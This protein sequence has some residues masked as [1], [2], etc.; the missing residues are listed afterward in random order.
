MLEHKSKRVTGLRIWGLVRRLGNL[1]VVYFNRPPWVTAKVFLS[2]FFP[3]RLSSCWIRKAVRA[4]S[5]LTRNGSM[6]PCLVFANV[7]KASL[8]LNRYVIIIQR[9]KDGSLAGVAEHLLLTK[10]TRGLA[11]QNLPTFFGN[12]SLRAICPSNYSQR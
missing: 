4:L 9:W 10:Y 12:L 1:G 8:D 2:L 3:S 5:K 11:P 7:K 6:S